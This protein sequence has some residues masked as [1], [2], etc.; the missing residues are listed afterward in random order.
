MSN[1]T[2]RHLRQIAHHLGVP[3]TDFFDGETAPLPPMRALPPETE[4]AALEMLGLWS[5][6]RDPQDRER[7]LNMLRSCAART[8]SPLRLLPPQF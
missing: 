2:E 4:A 6:I 5:L 8:D 3:V 7:C 1:L